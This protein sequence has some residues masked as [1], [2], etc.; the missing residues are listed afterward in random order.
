MRHEARQTKAT[1]NTKTVAGYHRS[2]HDS[3]KVY[4]SDRY[5]ELTAS[6]K[7]FGLEI[8][9]S[10]TWI[11]VHNLREEGSNAVGA[12]L[13]EVVFKDFPADF[14]RFEKDGSISGAECVT[15]CMTKEF[16]RNHYAQFKNLYDV[17]LPRFGMVPTDECGMHVNIS[18]ANF[19][20]NDS[21]RLECARKLFYFI[22][23][24]YEL[25]CR[26]F[27]RNPNHT[28]YCGPMRN[29]Q[30]AKTMDPADYG[31]NHAVCINYGHYYEARESARRIELRIVGGQ[32]NFASFRNTME[33]LFCLL[34]AIKNCS[35]R[36][37]DDLQ[38][39]FKGCNKYVLSRLEKCR[40]EGVLP[41]TI[42]DAIE[43][44]SDTET[45]YL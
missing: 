6:D 7:A 34:D 21:K 3:L 25:S 16:I 40:N 24:N 8:E 37:L 27:M 45:V 28:H 36:D 31:D 19:G 42:Y 26:L 5:H 33:T 10:C 11:N 30:S 29:W 13:Q 4:T 17:Y 39:V 9:T 23:K 35:W 1:K 20:S 41:S 15:Q 22:N 32:R 38:K 12:L 43:A 18:L 14:I 2:N 44:N